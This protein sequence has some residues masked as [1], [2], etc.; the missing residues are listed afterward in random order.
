MYL[1]THTDYVEKAAYVAAQVCNPIPGMWRQED[2]K[3]GV[4]EHSWLYKLGI[5]PMPA[6]PA[7]WR[8]GQ[9]D[10]QFEAN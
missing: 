10:N 9:N 2:K 1:C 6:I 3:G 8:L 5:W 4:Q 7:F